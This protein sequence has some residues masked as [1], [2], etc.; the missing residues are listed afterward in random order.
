MA[1][2]VTLRNLPPGEPSPR[3]YWRSVSYDRYTGHGWLTSG[4]Q[5]IEHQANQTSTAPGAGQRVVEQDV[6]IMSDQGGL[7]YAA[8]TLVTAN[9]DYSVA[10]RA[11]EDYFGANI[12]GD[13]YRA[14]STVPVYSED[15]LRT[16]GNDYPAWVLNRYLALPAD[17]PPRVLDLARNLTATEPTPY[18]RARAIEKYLRT[19]PYT[20]DIAAPPTKRDVVDYFLFDLKRGYCDYYATSMVVLARAAGLPA[21]LVI[22]YVSGTYDNANRRYIVTEA[23]AHSWV[24]VYFPGYGWIEFEPTGGRAELDRPSPATAAAFAEQQESLPQPEPA[25]QVRPTLQGWLIV[26]IGLG[27][28]IAIGVAWA[29]T[30][31]WRLNRLAPGAA[32]AEIYR[33]LH[34][35]GQRLA[36]PAQA[37]DTPDEFANSFTDRLA[38][39][40]FNPRWTESLTTAA[41]ETRWLI[42]LHTQASYS[43]HSPTAAERARAVRTWFRLRWQLWVVWAL[44]PARRL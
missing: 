40:A 8:G 28:L 33:R 11:N 14:I 39:L 26:L 42:A 15:Q 29:A 41:Q 16:A 36:V 2:L 5:T 30:E 27:V 22:G 31:G 3:Y 9:Q 13:R 25:Q 32:A 35:H 4:T 23:D 38:D 17:V 19:Y 1:L 37:G 24:E 43:P 34:R 7:L 10:W 21:R 20:L 18:D 44:H 12:E 6:Q